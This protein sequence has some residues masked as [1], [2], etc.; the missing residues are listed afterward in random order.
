MPRVT[1]SSR[2]LVLLLALAVAARAGGGC[3]ST[4]ATA[5]TNA[6]A[7]PAPAGGQGGGLPAARAG[8]CPTSSA[9]C[10]AG[11]VLAPSVSVLEQGTNRI[12]FALF[13][14]AGKQL[15]G[16]GVALYIGDDR[17]LRRPRAVRGAQRVAEGLAAVREQADRDRPERGARRLRRRRAVQEER[18]VRDA[19]DRQARRPAGRDEPDRRAGR[20]QEGRAARR[21]ATRRRSSTR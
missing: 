3:G 4:P 11:P 6:R 10:R 19:G 9:T 12:G 7:R 15:S 2:L 8:R 13:D 17:R 16:A 5:A 14:N 20:R 18:Q 1:R 21:R